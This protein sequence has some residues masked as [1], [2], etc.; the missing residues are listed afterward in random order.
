MTDSLC[1]PTGGMKPEFYQS[2]MVQPHTML[3]PGCWQPTCLS[4]NGLINGTGDGG[5][6]QWSR[7]TIYQEHGVKE[8]KTRDVIRENGAKRRPCGAATRPAPLHIARPLIHSPACV[9][10]LITSSPRGLLIN[11]H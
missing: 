5:P 8:D 11:S 6:T 4:P 9:C 7:S 3:V 10:A 1:V 2:L